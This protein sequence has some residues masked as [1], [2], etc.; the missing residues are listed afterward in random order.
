MSETHLSGRHALRRH[1]QRQHN[2]QDL[3][4][5][6]L[7]FPVRSALHAFWDT[8]IGE[9]NVFSVFRNAS[10]AALARRLRFFH[11][12]VRL[13]TCPCL[14][15]QQLL[16]A[17]AL[18]EQFMGTVMRARGDVSECNT[19]DWTR[20]RR[21]ATFYFPYLSLYESPGG[22]GSLIRRT[23]RLSICWNRHRDW[24]Y[25]PPHRMWED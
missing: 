16:L 25:I 13:D 19:S 14:D 20:H 24:R 3:A 15:F 17:K 5:F 8:G 1:L 11:A 2:T 10:L 9:H 22:S 7:K 18:Q 23:P 21:T 6:R 12:F 4:V